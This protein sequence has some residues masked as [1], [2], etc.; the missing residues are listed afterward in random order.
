MAL[1]RHQIIVYGL[2]LK[3]EYELESRFPKLELVSYTLNVW[4]RYFQLRNTTLIVYIYIRVQHR[5]IG[6]YSIAG[7]I[8]S[9][10]KN[11]QL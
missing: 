10:E 8:T 3:Y 5:S 7:I 6:L 1:R 9:G 4:N 11:D 2:F